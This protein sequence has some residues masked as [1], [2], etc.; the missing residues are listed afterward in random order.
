MPV[1]GALKILNSQL[2]LVLRRVVSALS[3]TDMEAVSALAWKILHNI[4]FPL[5]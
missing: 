5:F 4:Y 1:I 2:A 3:V